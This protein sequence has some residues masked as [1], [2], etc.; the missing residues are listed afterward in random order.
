MIDTFSLLLFM[1]SAP[2]NHFKAKR[3]GMEFLTLSLYS[4]IISLYLFNILSSFSIIQETAFFKSSSFRNVCTGITYRFSLSKIS[5]AIPFALTEYPT[6][7]VGTSDEYA[8][9]VE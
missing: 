4:I 5:L 7:N 8:A 9:I 3:F 6:T 1:Y 2:L